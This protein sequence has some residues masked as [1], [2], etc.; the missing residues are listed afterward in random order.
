MDILHVKSH[1]ETRRVLPFELAGVFLAATEDLK[2]E[3]L[4]RWLLAALHRLWMQ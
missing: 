1:S 2:G 3:S 4:V